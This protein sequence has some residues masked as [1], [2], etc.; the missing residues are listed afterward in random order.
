[1]K[2]IDYVSIFKK[3]YYHLY[4]NSSSSRAEKL[5]GDVTKLL[6]YS[7][8]VTKRSDVE[9]SLSGEEISEF[10]SAE[11]KGTEYCVEPFALDDACISAI[12]PE[13]LT[14][15]LEHAPAHIVG[16]AVQSM[17]GPRARGDKGQF[18]TPESVVK[19]IVDITGVEDNDLIVDPACGT[20]G[21]LSAAKEK[22]ASACSM[23]SFVGADKDKDMANLA[24]AVMQIEAPN[25]SA[26]GCCNSLEA[27]KELN[28]L[29]KFLGKADKVITNP[30][31]GAKIG[32]T[33]PDILSHYHFGHVW[34]SPGKDGKWKMTDKVVRKQDPQ[35]LFIELCVDLL[36]EGGT[37]GI[38]LPEGIFYSKSLGY[39]WQYLRDNGE[40]LAL[41][42]A[43]RN[44]FQPSTDTKTNILIYKKST[45]NNR[46]DGIWFAQAHHCGH[47]RR[48][49]TKTQSGMPIKDDFKTIG[50]QWAAREKGG[51]VWMRQTPDNG[52]YVPRYYVNR[53]FAG[54]GV[55]GDAVSLG[56]LID[57][58]SLILRSGHEVGNDAY[59]TG[60][61]PYVRT[62]DIN[63]FEVSSDPTNS[64]SEEVYEKF[65][66]QENLKPGDILFIAD[67]RYRIGKTAIITEHNTKCVVQSH[68]DILTVTDS[69]PFSCYELLYLINSPEVQSQI[70]SLVFISSTLGT[71]GSRIREIK[72]PVPQRDESWIDSIDRFKTLL[73]GRASLLSELKGYE[74]SEEDQS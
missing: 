38:V 22:D 4:S 37:L 9:V 8:A 20:G 6:L 58:G 45:D 16:E 30:P 64:V 26:I 74:T 31:F 29:H 48:G 43:P 42:D 23:V 65:R 15:D 68:I 39:I 3:I 13:L 10:L 59:G 55:Q 67:G 24:F 47:D 19:C 18:F 41:I 57:E 70:R 71:I 34:T 62:S 49:R 54:K 60:S 2:K 66:A 51:S 33:D 73:E 5:L 25:D 53:A 14:L 7:Y 28:F 50:E 35:I 44:T 61:I 46:N 12:L 1:M 21:F 52:L 56:Q 36:K 69:A 32:I 40:I 27:F 72:I 17:I 63:N 11:Y